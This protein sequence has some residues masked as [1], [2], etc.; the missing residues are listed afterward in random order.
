MN[1]AKTGKQ[2]NSSNYEKIGKKAKNKQSTDSLKPQNV[3]SSVP[4]QF[5]NKKSDYFIFF[6]AACVSLKRLILLFYLLCLMSE[7][8]DVIP[9]IEERKRGIQGMDSLKSQ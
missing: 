7:I 1:D 6:A 3:S 2:S 5:V 9:S 8:F 4:G